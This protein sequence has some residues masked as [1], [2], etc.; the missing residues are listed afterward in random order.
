[1]GLIMTATITSETQTLEWLSVPR[2]LL[3]AVVLR[4]DIR[5]DAPHRLPIGE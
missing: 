4:L 5:S 2:P 1:M 3:L